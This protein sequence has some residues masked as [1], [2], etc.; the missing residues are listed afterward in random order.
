MMINKDRSR[1]RG[2]VSQVIT[3][4]LCEQDFLLSFLNKPSNVVTI[5]LANCDRGCEVLL[6][7]FW[8]IYRLTM[9]IDYS[10]LDSYLFFENLNC[11]LIQNFGE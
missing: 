10:L 9:I 5:F 6:K 8:N 3:P 4:V 1:N 11:F 2:F 7:R